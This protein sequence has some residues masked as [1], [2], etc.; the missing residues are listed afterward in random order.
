V[1][2]ASRGRA[3]GRKVRFDDQNA[4]TLGRECIGDRGT[5]NAG[6]D[7]DRVALHVSVPAVIESSLMTP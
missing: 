3:A 2:H 5:D 7:D 4:R 6:S 1:T